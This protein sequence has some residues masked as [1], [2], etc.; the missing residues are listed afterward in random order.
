MSD[1][2]F[3]LSPLIRPAFN[4]SQGLVRTSTGNSIQARES[5]TLYGLRNYT[6][7]ASIIGRL[8]QQIYSA[9]AST[10][11][12]A[13]ATPVN[14][15]S[16][17]QTLLQNLY[18]TDSNGNTNG[19]QIKVLNNDNTNPGLSAGDTLVVQDATGREVSRT[20]ITNQELYDLRFR[21]S[22]T[23]T[24]ARLGAGWGFSEAIVQ[25][26]NNTL[27]Q[28]ET[29]SYT[30]SNGQRATETVL[31]RNAFWETVQRGANRY[32][33]MRERD[34]S[35]KP[36][37][38]SDALN[39]IFNN[40]QHYSFDCATP[41]RLL[42]LK[43]TLDTI[44]AD[45]FNQQAGRLLLSSWYDQHDSSGFDGGFITK[46]RT[47]PAGAVSVN[48]VSNL[49][50]E[51]ALFDTTQGNSLRLG[52][53]YY[54]DL[55]G[56]NK[57]ASQGWNAV[58]LGR[59]TDGSHRFWSTNIGIVTVNFTPNTWLPDGS[60]AGYYLGAVQASP[61]VNRLQSWDQSRSI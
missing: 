33:L 39:D 45:D 56:D 12:P 36:L 54:F 35:G 17:E 53:V 2:S 26:N 6:A 4:Q 13:V 18:A 8:L 27:A 11:T 37:S 10:P 14:L 46:T 3:A 55:P 25:I 34:D 57:S 51:T 44:G 28:P 21:E 49:Q 59:E 43:A 7:T 30:S 38:P 48:G 23:K 9:P 42:N 50:G 47:A 60:L 16:Y 52:D 61:N 41:M 29:R 40:R 31:A 32:L 58:Y 19:Q 20:T 22:I 24:A 5:N 15:S 1:G